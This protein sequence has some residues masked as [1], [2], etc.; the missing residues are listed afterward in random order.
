VLLGDGM[1]GKTSLQRG[2]FYGTPKPTHVDA[3]TIQ[4]RSPLIAFDRT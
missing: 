1:A 4:V 3:R 2:L